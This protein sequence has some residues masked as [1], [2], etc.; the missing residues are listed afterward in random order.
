VCPGP[1]VE[2]TC[3]QVPAFQLVRTIRAPSPRSKS[4]QIPVPLTFCSAEV[5][6]SSATTESC[7]FLGVKQLPFKDIMRHAIPAMFHVIL[8]NAELTIEAREVREH[9][10]EDAV[11]PD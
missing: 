6:S 1:V 8:S 10:H 9:A 4:P 7:T 11:I 3:M 2:H 5:C